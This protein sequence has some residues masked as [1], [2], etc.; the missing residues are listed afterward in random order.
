VK[1]SHIS[2]VN[3]PSKMGVK[4]TAIE[5]WDYSRLT[6]VNGVEAEEFIFV[7]MDKADGSFQIWRGIE[8]ATDRI[9]VL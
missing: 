4:N 5:Y 6:G 9:T 7:E 8:V 2:S 3:I 1:D